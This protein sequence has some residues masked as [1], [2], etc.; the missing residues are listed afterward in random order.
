MTNNSWKILYNDKYDNTNIDSIFLLCLADCWFDTHDVT[1]KSCTDN[2]EIKP[3]KCIAGK[4][5]PINGCSNIKCLG[6]DAECAPS[7]HGCTTKR[8]FCHKP[9]ICHIYII[10][11][12][13]IQITMLLIGGF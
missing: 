11:F 3:G 12:Y 6:N 10:L 1:V 4:G 7:C 5:C 8:K 13:D 9:G 2:R